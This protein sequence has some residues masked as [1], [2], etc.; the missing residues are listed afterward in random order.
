MFVI[1][2]ISSLLFFMDE[3]YYPIE[4]YYDL[5]LMNIWIISRLWLLLTEQL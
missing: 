2:C 3:Y 5:F 1:V 4:I